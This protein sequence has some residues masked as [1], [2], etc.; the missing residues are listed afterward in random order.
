MGRSVAQRLLELLT[1]NW[2]PRT[3]RRDATVEPPYLTR[4]YVRNLPKMLD[5]SFPFDNLG[6]P[7]EGVVDNDESYSVFLHRFGQD[8]EPDVHCHPWTWGF[9][10]ILSGGYIEE[11]YDTLTNTYSTRV[12]TAPAVNFL[13]H[14]DFHRV[15]LI[16][17]EECWSIFFTGKRVSDW[18]FID[19]RTGL[20]MHWATYFER[21]RKLE[22]KP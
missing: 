21:S 4:W 2:R 20:Y 18:G 19:R 15:T 7:R 22:A 14:G 11:R 10:I 8:D 1:R 9:S 3:I 16:G 5:G 12:L 17:E 13:R 6:R